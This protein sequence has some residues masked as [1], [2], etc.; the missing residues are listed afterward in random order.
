MVP[1]EGL[2]VAPAT[3]QD[4]LNRDTVQSSRTY[5]SRRFEGNS[6]QNGSS[7]DNKGPQ[8]LCFHFTT[9]VRGY[10]NSSRSADIL[11]MLCKRNKTKQMEGGGQR[12]SVPRLISFHFDIPQTSLLTVGPLQSP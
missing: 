1:G 9:S 3:T 8:S 2:L 10:I 4:E 12:L 7:L 6:R 5:S 11:N